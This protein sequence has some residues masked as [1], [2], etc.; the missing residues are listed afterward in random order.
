MQNWSKSTRQKKKPKPKKRQANWSPCSTRSQSLFFF[1]KLLPLGWFSWDGLISGG[2]SGV[3]LWSLAALDCS[4][5]VALT[6]GASPGWAWIWGMPRL[7]PDLLLGQINCDRKGNWIPGEAAGRCQG[8]IKH[9]FDTLNVH[10]SEKLQMFMFFF[11]GTG[12]Y[13]NG[14]SSCFSHLEVTSSENKRSP[15]SS[16]DF[17]CQ[18]PCCNKHMKILL[19][20]CKTWKDVEIPDS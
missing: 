19:K 14:F 7:F 5:R 13:R 17:Q 9:A 4:I 15:W 20:R 6:L 3:T 11:K 2:S 8:H 1:I 18:S 10:L 12:Y 16:E